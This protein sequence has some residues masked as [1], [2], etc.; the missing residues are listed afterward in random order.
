[1]CIPG[2]PVRF[3]LLLTLTDADV[4]V[5]KRNGPRNHE[6]LGM[7]RSEKNI[8]NNAVKGLS[9]AASFLESGSDAASG[10]DMED[11][12][13][14]MDPSAKPMVQS[15]VD[16]ASD[17]YDD[18]DDDTYFDGKTE[19]QNKLRPK[20]FEH[21]PKDALPLWDAEPPT[22]EPQSDIEI[23]SSPPPADD[24]GLTDGPPIGN[25]NTGRSNSLDASLIKALQPLGHLAQERAVRKGL[26]WVENYLKDNQRL[27]DM[28]TS[29]IR[30]FWEVAV[31]AEKAGLARYA[32]K[33]ARRLAKTFCQTHSSH[34][35]LTKEDMLDAFEAVA[36]FKDLA[37]ESDPCATK[38]ARRVFQIGKSKKDAGDF[39]ED[40]S[41]LSPRGLYQ[42]ANA[43]DSTGKQEAKL[44][45]VVSAAYTLFR[46]KSYFPKK[47]KLNPHMDLIWRTLRWRSF[48]NARGDRDYPGG[49]DDDQSF[50]EQAYNLVNL[51]VMESNDGQDELVKNH[52]EWI[53][54]FLEQNYPHVIAR[55]DV[56]L[57]GLFT[58]ILRQVGEKDKAMAGTSFLLKTQRQDGSW[59]AFHFN[60]QFQDSSTPQRPTGSTYSQVFPTWCAILGLLARKKHVPG[61]YARAFQRE[62]EEPLEEVRKKAE[63]RA[64]RA[65]A[66]VVLLDKGF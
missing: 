8:V 35:L 40:S 24:F 23:D 31:S 16:D 3:L 50:V 59:R 37:M 54:P 46:A 32:E 11:I 2:W 33:T 41:L 9:D 39:L 56:E 52:I 55:R 4:L 65:P 30:I 64:K 47:V 66:K 43:D 49:D 19:E 18:D 12:E 1:M 51:P 63:E 26:H 61:L 58:D 28:G 42:L 17:D 5:H 57:T 34:H 6:H 27:M 21:I 22:M 45:D 36:L 29:G 25:E 10:D 38:M 7:L 60:D 20:A 62:V 53:V 15:A 48:A 13:D 44:F 14:A